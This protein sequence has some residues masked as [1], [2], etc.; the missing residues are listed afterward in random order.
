MSKL[1]DQVPWITVSGA[2]SGGISI[3]RLSRLQA[4]STSVVAAA[5][6]LSPTGTSRS[7]SGAAVL[8]SVTPFTVLACQPWTF[9]PWAGLTSSPS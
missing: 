1:V 3:V 6:S 4:R 7:R 9:M 8:I 2:A 5:G